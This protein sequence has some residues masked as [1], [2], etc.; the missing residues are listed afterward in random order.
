MNRWIT[1]MEQIPGS[2]DDFVNDTA[3]WMER[4]ENI[5]EAILEQLRVKPDSD[6]D[7]V[8]LVLWNCL[9]IGEPLEIVDDEEPVKRPFKVAML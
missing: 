8:T 2:Y 1:L 6:T 3:D 7:D 9:G 5:R 4:D